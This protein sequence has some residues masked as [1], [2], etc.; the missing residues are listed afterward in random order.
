L[1]SG[2]KIDDSQLQIGLVTLDVVSNPGNISS[3]V[4]WHWREIPRLPNSVLATEY[5]AG[6][7]TQKREVLLGFGDHITLREPPRL[8]R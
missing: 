5:R 8:H 3:S 1:L 6:R 4:S 7:Y 2:R